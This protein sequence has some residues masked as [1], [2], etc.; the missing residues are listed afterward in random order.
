MIAPP[1]MII[2]VT[3]EDDLYIPGSSQLEVV[4]KLT[5]GTSIQTM[6]IEGQNV[7]HRPSV[8]VTT[9][10]VQPN[11]ENTNHMVPIRLLNLPLDGGTVYKGTKLGEASVKDESYSVLVSEVQED[12]HAIDKQEDVPEA[13]RKLLWQAVESTAEDLTNEQHQQLFEVLLKHADVFAAES[14]DLAHTV[15][16]GHYVNT[17]NA[18]PIRQPAHCLPFFIA[19]MFRNS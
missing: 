4:A 7:S 3:L 17:G 15:Q 14:S 9:A 6:L 1:T 13:K 8:L 10:V 19:K 18:I 16:L 5:G 2:S 12:L 11:T